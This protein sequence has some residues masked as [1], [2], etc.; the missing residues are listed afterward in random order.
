MSSKSQRRA[1]PSRPKPAARRSGALRAN[2]RQSTP[3]SPIPP[4][5]LVWLA[6]YLNISGY[7]EE[8]RNFVHGLR[9]KGIG[10]VAHPLHP[11][12]PGFYNTLAA[13]HPDMAHSLALSMK[14]PPRDLRIGVIHAPAE[15]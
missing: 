8:A 12:S 11:V 9:R 15:V 14:E 1:R 7:G 2:S 6:P 4:G 10:V 13:G 5:T 3:L